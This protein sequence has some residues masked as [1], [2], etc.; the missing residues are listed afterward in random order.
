[1]SCS[2]QFCK[3]T[4]RVGEIDDAFLSRIQVAIGYETLTETARNQIWN[5]FFQRLKKE[6]SDI[7]VTE[8]SKIFLRSDKTLRK[9][10][11]NGREIRNG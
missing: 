2:K 8:R 5:N 7:T 11:L 9:L 4:N 3:T 1:M 6:R 10:E